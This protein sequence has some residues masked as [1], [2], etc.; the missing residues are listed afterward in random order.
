MQLNNRG[1]SKEGGKA[2]DEKVLDVMPSDSG[3]S[4]EQLKTLFNTIDKDG[5]G[6]IDQDWLEIRSCFPCAWHHGNHDCA[7]GPKPII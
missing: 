5:S 1:G 4:T 7:S 3:V 6:G 2:G